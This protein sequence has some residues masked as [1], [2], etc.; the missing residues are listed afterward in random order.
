MFATKININ[1]CAK[2]CNAMMPVAMLNFHEANLLTLWQSKVS[3]TAFGLN[4]GV[5][6]HDQL[7]MAL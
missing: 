1:E 3:R 7:Y 2:D 6:A 4:Q 5:F